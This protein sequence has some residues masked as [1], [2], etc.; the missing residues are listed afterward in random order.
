MDPDTR[1]S[2]REAQSKEIRKITRT[3]T[4]TP[5]HQVAKRQRMVTA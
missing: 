3:K 2:L 5:L 1:A 4:Q